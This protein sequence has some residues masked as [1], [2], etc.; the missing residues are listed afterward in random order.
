MKKITLL[1][2][3]AIPFLGISQTWDF[4]DATNQGWSGL[5]GFTTSFVTEDGNECILLTT[6]DGDTVEKNPSIRNTS[7]GVVT[8]DKP[9]LAVTL[10]NESANG[11][12]YFRVSYPKEP[13]G[14]TYK[15]ITITAGDLNFKTYYVD[16]TGSNWTG[17]MDDLQLHFKTDGNVD[18]ILPNNP[19]NANIYIDKV[20][21]L[22][23][24]SGIVANPN[25]DDFNDG[26]YNSWGIDTST[27]TTVTYGTTDGVDGTAAAVINFD[28]TLANG[29]IKVENSY[30]YTFENPISED[31]VLKLNYYHKI[32]GLTG[33]IQVVFKLSIT[34][35]G[36]ETFYQGWKTPTGTF[37]LAPESRTVDDGTATEVT[38][39]DVTIFFRARNGDA[40]TK[41][42]IDN[43]DSS[44][45][46]GDGETIGIDDIK[47]D[48]DIVFFPNPVKDILNIS[49][50]VAHIELYNI[51]GQKIVAL[52][53]VNSIDVSNLEGG[54]YIA[55]VT[56]SEGVIT[57][58]R[59]VKN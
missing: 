16:L 57:T 5:N 38:Y 13:S 31:H 44:V 51:M 36:T 28:G 40:T 42:Y 2:L 52:S 37:T 58:K 7:S 17:D 45:L 22:Y 39:D 18:Y 3:F 8:G 27:G 21:M 41:I 56:S 24:Y 43:I 59:F 10:K 34:G 48:L 32:T 35:G 54:S 53:N 15:N 49:T 50:E 19:D 20:E 4:D 29:D 30:T 47:N 14:R 33:D 12:T 46:D 23:N 1:I 55:R 11:P 25:F 6:E 26:L 9:Y